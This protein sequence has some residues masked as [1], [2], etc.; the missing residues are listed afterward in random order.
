MLCNSR[1]LHEKE[2]NFRPIE[3]E[4]LAVDMTL[5][6]GRLFL[7]GNDNFEIVVDHKPLV[8]IF[9][10]KP[11]HEID[12][13]LLQDFK[14]RSL[15]FTFK[16]R[17]IKGIKTMQN[18]LTRYPVN[19]PD[20]EDVERTEKCHAILLAAISKS[21]EIVA[22]TME[23]IKDAIQTDEQYKQL[24]NAIRNASFATVKGIP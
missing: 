8:K 3:G 2:K 4:G 23:K 15:S 12:N 24:S 9:G 5:K 22:I 7:Q 1:N 10:D 20:E 18:T 19:D 16:M 11:L 6:K 21:T 14:E 17:Y 13:P